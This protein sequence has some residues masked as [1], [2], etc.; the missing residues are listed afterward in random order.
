[1][2]MKHYGNRSEF[3]DLRDAELLR[4]YHSSAPGENFADTPSS[5]FWVSETRAANVMVMMDKGLEVPS[6]YPDKRRMYMELYHRLRVLRREKP[7]LPL[8]R[9]MEEIVS[10]PSPSFYMARATAE[11][12]VADMI[13]R[14][15][16]EGM[17]RRDSGRHPVPRIRRRVEGMV[18]RS[19][20][21]KES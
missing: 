6:K 18:S 5:R 14:R 21:G 15:R 10:S 2:L 20:K 19:S 16:Q 12:R 3:A 8:I 7:G 4:A 13:R 11:R 17:A 9:A 1:M